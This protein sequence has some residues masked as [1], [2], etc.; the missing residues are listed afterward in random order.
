MTL[1]KLLMTTS[2]TVF[3]ALVSTSAMAE[4]MGDP[5]GQ[6]LQLYIEGATYCTGATCPQ[7]ATS[8]QVPNQLYSDSWAISGTTGLRLWVMADT[9]AYDVHLVVSYNDISGNAPVM[10]FTPRKLGD[11][12]I[13]GILYNAAVNYSGITDP[14][15]PAGVGG[16][17]VNGNLGSLENNEQKYDP[18]TRNW[19]VIDL[20]DMTTEETRRANLTPGGG[21]SATSGAAEGPDTFDSQLNIYDITFTTPAKVGQVVNFALWACVTDG[22]PFV[23]GPGGSDG[24]EYLNMANSHD[25]QW[26]QRAGVNV[27]E[28]ASLTLLGAGLLGLGYFGRRR[29]A[30]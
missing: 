15:A 23:D 14:S 1:N 11:S 19:V 17:V 13:P 18:G 3:A 7:S 10:V 26:L 22:C 28:P 8:S 30:A 2:A 20:G 25:A 9:E 12:A 4:P 29:K 24:I 27:P 6:A 16:Q 5:G 21:F